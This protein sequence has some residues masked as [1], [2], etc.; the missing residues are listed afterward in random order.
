MT[1]SVILCTYNRS[2]RLAKALESVARSVVAASLAWEVLVIDNNSSDRTREVTDD[3]CRMYPEHFR[4]IFERKQGKSHALN[5]GIRAARGEI[6]AFMDDDVTVEPMW[7]QNLVA[8]LV[9]GDYAGSGGRI[10]L[11]P[12]TAPAWLRLHGP[13]GL[14]GMLA[15]FDLG[16]KPAELVQPPWGTNMAFRKEMFQ[17]YGDFRT[18]LG[19]RPGS[20]MRDEDCEF[21]DRL[22]K[23]GERLRY[24][25][26]AVV[27]HGVPQHRLK[28]EY[29]LKFWFDHARG[30]IRM[31][32]LRPN[33]LGIP[34]RYL[35]MFKH[36]VII[37]PVKI[38]QWAFT[39][40]PQERFYRKCWVWYMGGA[41]LEIYRRWFVENRFQIEDQEI[42]AE[43][44]P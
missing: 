6:L 9:N 37:A 20:E 22:I 10:L 16:E 27:F 17:K 7:L 28:K 12:F 38:L 26:S 39:F 14:A 41:I 11:E 13:K 23:A 40:E 34:R 31:M 8:P 32:E 30:T 42:R 29:F 19:P 35:T 4:Y 21:G 36:V 15:L 43:H 44:L 18:D 25:P 24:E 2:E 5:S 1:I 3:F 33:V